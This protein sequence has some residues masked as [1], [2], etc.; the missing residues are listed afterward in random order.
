MLRRV[1]LLAVVVC[2]ALFFVNAII[3]VAVAAAVNYDCAPCVERSDYTVK[4]ITHGQKKIGFW[5]QVQAA[6]VQ[7][8]RD[9]RGIDFQFELAAKF[10][11]DTMASEIEA[12]ATSDTPPDALIVT[13]PSDAVANAVKQVVDAGTPVFGFNSGYLS[14]EELGVLAYVAM[15][16]TLGGQFAAETTLRKAEAADINITQ[17]LFIN[18]EKGNSAFDQRF[19][20]YSTVMNASG[21]N[22]TQF[23]VDINNPNTAVDLL[24]FAELADCKHQVVLCSNFAVFGPVKK[25]FDDCGFPKPYLIGTFDVNDEV[26]EAIGNNDLAYAVDQQQYLQGLSTETRSYC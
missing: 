15:D 4:A 23:Y 21:V 7:S 26:Y 3:T 1:G 10:D 9:M 17:A 20:G 24:I 19:D 13:I 16:E 12:I 6:A 25:A 14:A 18:I 8:G 22:A 5:Q 11:P 2:T